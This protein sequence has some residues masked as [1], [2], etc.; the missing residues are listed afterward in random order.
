LFNIDNVNGSYK[1]T[2]MVRIS[3]FRVVNP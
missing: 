2:K 1:I 3:P